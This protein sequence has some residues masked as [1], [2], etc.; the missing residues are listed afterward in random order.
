M[1]LNVYLKTKKNNLFELKQ[2]IIQSKSKEI[3]SKI[4]ALKCKIKKLAKYIELLIFKSN[5]S[6]ECFIVKYNNFTPLHI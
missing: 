4:F 3:L 1:A 2:T 6:D 5:V